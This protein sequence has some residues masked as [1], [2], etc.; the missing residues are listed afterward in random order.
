MSSC[1]RAGA[2]CGRTTEVPRCFGSLG[3][4]GGADDA[5]AVPGPLAA[6][7]RRGLGVAVAAQ[8]RLT[9]RLAVGPVERTRLRPA[10]AMLAGD[11]ATSVRSAAAWARPRLRIASISAV[12]A[13]SRTPRPAQIAA[14]RV[15]RSAVGAG[16]VRSPGAL[17]SPAPRSLVH[18]VQSGAP[19]S[20]SS[21]SAVPEAPAWPSTFRDVSGPTPSLAGAWRTPSSRFDSRRLHSQALGTRAFFL[22]GPP[23]SSISRKS[24]P[25]MRGPEERRRVDG[26]PSRAR[27]VRRERRGRAGGHLTQRG[28]PRQRA[29]D[30]EQPP[31]ADRSRPPAQARP[32]RRRGSSHDGEGA[33]PPAYLGRRQ[34]GRTPERQRRAMARPS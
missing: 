23:V 14:A 29:D 32:A 22:A 15:S 16:S 26:E 33:H 18:L 4:G 17:R 25:H 28:L 13:P 31:G 5:L 3:A 21:S 6:Q 9:A 10:V 20:P 19:R 8:V 11:H 34:P 1:T 24:S 12:V 2:S 27:R 30:Q 7:Q